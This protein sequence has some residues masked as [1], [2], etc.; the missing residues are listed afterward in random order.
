M[1]AAIPE[2][3]LGLAGKYPRPASVKVFAPGE[4][5]AQSIAL[6]EL[7]RFGRKGRFTYTLPET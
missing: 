7:G 2:E 3:A 1:I 5:C 4:D 6:C